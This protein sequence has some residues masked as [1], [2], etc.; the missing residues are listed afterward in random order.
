MA[1]LDY[2][3]GMKLCAKRYILIFSLIFE[4][5]LLFAQ[6]APQGGGMG[7]GPGP[8]GPESPGAPGP[9]KP[10]EPG[11]FP[12]PPPKD[13]EKIMKYRG[14]R[15]Y[16]DNIPLRIIQTECTHVDD[17]LVSLSIM[18]N[19]SINPR[20]VRPGTILINNKPLPP[21]TRFAFNKKGDT[22]K[23]MFPVNS[24]TFKLQVLKVRSFDG[25]EI[26]PV[27]L[28]IEVQKKL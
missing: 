23:I 5:F 6:G 24:N 8:G 11:H 26:E 4:G 1:D 14:N 10:G 9:G 13:S 19:Q 21:H 28:L 15:T 17:K 27:E 3:Y 12:P 25:S 2:N 16:T 18:F 20:S 22:V 7:P